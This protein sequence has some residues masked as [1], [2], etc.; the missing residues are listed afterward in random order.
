MNNDE[1]EYVEKE[2]E[3]DEEEGNKDEGQSNN[4]EQ[5]TE[6]NEKENKE[7]KETEN[8]DVVKRNNDEQETEDHVL[9]IEEDEQT[10]KE[11][12][13][14]EKKRKRNEKTKRRVTR[15]MSIQSEKNKKMKKEKEKNDEEE[16]AQIKDG[17]PKILTRMSPKSFI[18]VVEKLSDERKKEVIEMGFEPLLLL[19]VKQLPSSLGHWVVDKFDSRS[20]SLMLPNKE[21]VHITR[22]SVHYTLGFPRGAINIQEKID[23]QAEFTYEM[24]AEWRKQF[25]NERGQVKTGVL[26]KALEES[27]EEGW[28]FK[29]NFLVLLVTLLIEGN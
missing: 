16:D 25:P 27:R 14:F 22:E 17:F 2:R 21:K 4:D 11:R 7:D 18:E 5:D 12:E 28:M 19:Q 29:K 24:V 9:E 20:V 13:L 3:Q 6:A 10:R 1:P 15:S 26:K 23:T 8:E